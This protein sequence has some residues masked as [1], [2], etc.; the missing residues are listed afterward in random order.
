[1]ESAAGH[2]QGKPAKGS[3]TKEA[4]DSKASKLPEAA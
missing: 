4:K 2:G 1:M 3:K